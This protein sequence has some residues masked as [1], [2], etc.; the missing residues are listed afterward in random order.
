[1]KSLWSDEEAKTFGEDPFQLRIYTSRLLGKEPGLVLHGGG[2]T[3]VKTKAKNLFG[4]DENVILI[5][6]SGCNLAT[7]QADEFASIKLDVLHRIITLDTLSDMDMIRLQGSAM[8]DPAGPLPSLEAVLHANIPF[9]YVDHTHADAVVTI[10]NHPNG[11]ALIRNIYKDMVLVIPYVKPGFMLAKKIFEM[12]QNMT[13]RRFEGIIILHHGVF[14]FADDA[15]TSYERMIRL[16]SLAENYLEQQGWLEKIARAEAKEDLL[17]LSRI[18]RH[19]SLARGCALLAKL[20][21]SSRACGFANLSNVK[22]IATRGPLTSDHLIRTKPKPVILGKN[23]EQD[24]SDYALSY[25][26]YFE[27]HTDDTQTCFDLAPRWGV[28]PLHGT[29]AFG[30]NIKETTMVSDICRQTIQAV[31]WGESIGGWQPLSEK[32]MFDME[33]WQL[34][35]TKLPKD[36]RLLPLQGKVAMVTGA[37]SGIGFACMEMLH[38]QGA[39]VVGLD[40]NPKITRR[41]NQ[42]DRVGFVCD[43]TEGKA[44]R[45]AVEETIRRFGGLDILIPNAGIFPD[46]QRIEDIN[47]AIWTQSMDV[48]LSSQQHLLKICIPY[49]KQGIDAAVVF[50]S[51]K[52]VPAPGPGAAAYSVA[53]AGQTQLARIAAMELG[54]DGIRVNVVH[55]NAVY[56]TALWTQDILESR[57]SHYGYTVEEYKKNNCLKTEV[58]SKDVATLV[59]AMVGPAFAKT[60]GAQVPIDGGNVRVI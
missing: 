44:V 10:T 23:V 60:T 30:R 32:E 31:Q 11:E 3:S 58:S 25:K 13:W 16:V 57:A 52:N 4:E 6:G 39:A 34:Q 24:I 7:I 53:K 51:S 54:G 36:D 33:Y 5:K 1:M 9:K 15:R 22:S 49:L 41:F 55:P 45:E 48:N 40:I 35:Q 50:I 47:E 17:T 8:T 2:N 18:R 14:T 37:A 26:A 38:E 29:I 43:I 59:C 19:V 20:D 46:S 12:T 27:R 21:R 28:W 42:D 56:D